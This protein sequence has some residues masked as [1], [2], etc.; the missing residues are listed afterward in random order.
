MSS[1]RVRGRIF[2]TF[3]PAADHIRVFVDEIERDKALAM[4]PEFVSKLLWG[5]KVAGL[6]IDLESAQPAVV[7]ALVTAA[8]EHKS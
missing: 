7:K 5:G 1:F 6:R 3:P 4:H 2:V 8:W